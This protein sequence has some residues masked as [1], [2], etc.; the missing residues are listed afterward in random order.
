MKKNFKYFG[1]AWLVA[2]ALFN[3]I[4]FIIP[5]EIAGINRF[6]QPVFW[7]TYALISVAFILQLVSACVVCNKNTAEK[8]FLGIPLLKSGYLAV[9]LSLVVGTVFMVV[10]VIPTWIGAIV[11]LLVA[12]FF[13]IGT[14]KAVAVADMV[15]NVGSKVEKKTEFMKTAVVEVESIMAR[16]T[17]AE[18]QAETKKVYEALRYSDYMSCPELIKIEVHIEDHIAQL[19]V[20]V[21]NEDFEMV[22]VETKELLL[23]IKERNSKCK[24]LK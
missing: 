14:I 21:T 15:V 11:C 5:A 3:A 12:G 10:P 13:A 20:A 2:I 1:I 7:I 22:Q 4:T 9:T 23:L 18:I 16:A 19:K 6:E 8:V 24:M 17:T